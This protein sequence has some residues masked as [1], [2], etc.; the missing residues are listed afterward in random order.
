MCGMLALMCG[1]KHER[2]N[3]LH[4]KSREAVSKH[5]FCSNSVIFEPFRITSQHGYRIIH[6]SMGGGT[7][8]SLDCIYGIYR[9]ALDLGFTGI[10]MPNGL[11][12]T[13]GMSSLLVFSI[14]IWFIDSVCNPIYCR[15][16]DISYPSTASNSYVVDSWET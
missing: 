5:F 16:F 15:H 7:S 13:I 1:Q 10:A 9:E 3:L 14:D 6:P 11:L 2:S 12:D 8:Q 4:L